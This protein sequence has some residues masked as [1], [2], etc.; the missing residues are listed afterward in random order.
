MPATDGLSLLSLPA[1]LLVEVFCSLPSLKDVANLGASCKV[2]NQLQ[3]RHF[4]YIVDHVSL[5]SIPCYEDLRALVADQGHLAA[6]QPVTNM[7]LVGCLFRTS[8]NI[9]KAIDNYHA[10]MARYPHLDPQ[11]PQVL[12]LTE[13]TRF[14][15][16]HYQIWGLMLLVEQEKE[17]RIKSMGL[18]QACLLSDLLCVFDPMVIDDP[19]IGR[20]M[21]EDSV[22]NR[23]LLN[24]V[25]QRRN[26]EFFKTHARYYRPLSWSPYVYPCRHAWWCDRVQG[27]FKSMVSGTLFVKEAEDDS[28]DEEDELEVIEIPDEE[29]E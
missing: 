4:S 17:E 27:L 1:E 5:Q 11:V 24:R 19:M 3:S 13:K 21:R 29:A 9:E 8:Q 25:R 18:E 6:D 7:S 20:I 15:K 10:Q 23:R 26:D 22:S 16:A 2:V 14:I 12:S 28:E